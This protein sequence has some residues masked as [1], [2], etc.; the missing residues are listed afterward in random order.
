MTMLIGASSALAADVFPNYSVPSADPGMTVTYDVATTY[1][2]SGAVFIQNLTGCNQVGPTA[3]S[4]DV[5]SGAQP[6]DVH[7]C[8][9]FVIYNGGAMQAQGTFKITVGGTPPDTTAPVVQITSPAD[10][11]TFT[12]STTTIT[13]TVTDNAD[14]SPSC[15]IPNGVGITLIEGVNTLTVTCV[16]HSGNIGSDTVNVT[17]TIPPPPSGC[18]VRVSLGNV[19]QAEGDSDHQI[20]VPVTLSNPCATTV[21]LRYS[22]QSQ[23]A[24]AGSDYVAEV[25]QTLTIPAGTTKAGIPITIIGDSTREPSEIFFVLAFSDVTGVTFDKDKSTVVIQ[26]DDKK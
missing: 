19:Q 23:T 1:P 25:N 12:T 21:T 14:P 20:Y 24:D 3:M 11:T 7:T 10:G 5:P 26:N 22:T 18:E 17:Y 6:G 15:S 8:T 13:Y 4:Y 2:A 16:D 9:F